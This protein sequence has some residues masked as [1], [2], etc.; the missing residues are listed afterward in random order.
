MAGTIQVTSGI[1]VNNNALQ[2]SS[3]PKSFQAIQTTA[4]GVTPGTVTIATSVTDV[5]LTG[6][7]VPGIVHI[8]NLDPN[9]FVT[10]GLHDSTIF[11]PL[12]E[13]LPGE[14]WVFRLSRTILTA[15]T[16]ADKFAMLADTAAVKVLVAAF[17]Q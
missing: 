11:R 5:V 1:V 6:L 7:L 15:N 12:G 14:S 3:Y 9:N 2:Y 13:L 10:F 17:D 8:V 4:N 16:A